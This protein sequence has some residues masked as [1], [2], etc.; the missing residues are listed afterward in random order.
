MENR[1]FLCHDNAPA[2]RSVVVSNFLAKNNVTTLEY[3]SYFPDIVPTD[4]YPF[5]PLKS[6]LEGRRS[7]DADNIK[8][9]T[10]ELKR[11]S[12]NGLQECFHLLRMEC[13]LNGCTVFYFQK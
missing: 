9:A 1:Q 7:C 8:N 6:A 13:S 10:K 5:S 11:L 4:F 3:P 12:Q 2:H